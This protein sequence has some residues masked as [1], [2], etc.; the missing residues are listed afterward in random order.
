MSDGNNII[1]FEIDSED[2]A[3]R[4]GVCLGYIIQKIIDQWRLIVKLS[5]ILGMVLLTSSIRKGAVR[6]YKMRHTSSKDIQVNVI[7]Q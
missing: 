2:G 6:V 1:I 7:K 4:W 3:I 5:R